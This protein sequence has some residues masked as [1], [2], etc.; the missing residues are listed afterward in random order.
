[1]ENSIGNLII[2]V[3]SALSNYLNKSFTSAGLD[4]HTQ[5]MVI[6]MILWEKDGQRQQ[7]IADRTNKDKTSVA[8]LLAG[9]EKHGYVKRRVDRNDSRQK[10]I[11]LTERSRQ[12]MPQILSILRND[13]QS[14]QANI[15]MDDLKT[16]IQVLSDVHLNL[17]TDHQVKTTKN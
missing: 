4:L 15:H 11:F 5:Q 8:R 2:K 12:L 13:F 10:L 9:M 16:C 14:L 3:N 1:M 6:L 7:N 17:T